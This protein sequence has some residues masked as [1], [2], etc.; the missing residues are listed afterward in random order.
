MIDKKWV[1]QPSLAVKFYRV[2]QIEWLTQY[3]PQA[4]HVLQLPSRRPMCLRLQRLPRAT[5]HF[6]HHI[7]G[8]TT[9]RLHHPHYDVHCDTV[10]NLLCLF[11]LASIIHEASLFT[12]PYLFCNRHHP[13]NVHLHQGRGTLLST[14]NS[15][16]T[17]FHQSNLFWELR[18]WFVHYLGSL[19]LLRKRS[20]ILQCSYIGNNFKVV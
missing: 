5:H 8:H 16:S 6:C 12:A 7:N 9:G 1:S 3:Q 15:R 20:T 14:T 2:W 10:H 17:T 11:S 19:L 18:I 4:V 13:L